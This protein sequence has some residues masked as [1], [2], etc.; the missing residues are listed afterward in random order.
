M[1]NLK[2]GNPEKEK[3]EKGQF[4]KV[5]KDNYG[6]EKPKKKPYE[7]GTSEKGQSGNEKSEKETSEKEDP[8]EWQL[9]NGNYE[10]KKKRKEQSEK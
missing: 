2:K 6:K 7:M 8:G 3:T 1:A 9:R 5:K 10:I 4:W